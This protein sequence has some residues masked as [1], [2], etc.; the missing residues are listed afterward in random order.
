MEL[1]Q[2]G[3]L[4]ED[5]IS[6]AAEALLQNN[7]DLA[8]TAIDAREKDPAGTRRGGPACQPTARFRPA[9]WQGPAGDFRGAEDDL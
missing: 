7:P 6:A 3:A 9:P 1:I 5:G 8:Q 4:C 2:M